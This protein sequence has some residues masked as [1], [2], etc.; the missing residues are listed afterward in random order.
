MLAGVYGCGEQPVMVVSKG[1]VIVSN[2]VAVYMHLPGDYSVMTQEGQVLT[3]KRVADHVKEAHTGE[4]RWV[5][6]AADAIPDKPMWMELNY[7]TKDGMQGCEVIIHMH[8]PKDLNGAGW[9]REERHGKTNYAY[10]EKT[11]LLE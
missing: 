11:I 3:I 9:T 7:I 1:P 6:L 2:V 8:S 10:P 5:G 4:F